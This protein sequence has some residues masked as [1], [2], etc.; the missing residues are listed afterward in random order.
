[1]WLPYK[2][3]CRV[4]AILYGCP[5]RKAVRYGIEVFSTLSGLQTIDIGV[6]LQTQ[7]QHEKYRI[8]KALSKHPTLAPPSSLYI[9]F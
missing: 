7:N 2:S 9:T 8:K 6:I 3:S 5:H 1:L 4:G